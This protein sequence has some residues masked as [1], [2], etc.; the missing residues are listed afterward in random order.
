MHE[1]MNT[2]KWDGAT[3]ALDTALP[4]LP[5]GQSETGV[6][7]IDYGPELRR[8]GARTLKLVEMPVVFPEQSSPTIK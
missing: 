7:V 8:E 5:I 1:R 3:I 2:Y 4:D 6:Y